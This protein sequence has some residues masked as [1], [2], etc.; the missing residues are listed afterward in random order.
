[1]KDDP[2]RRIRFGP[3][4]ADLAAGEL[5]K[6]GRVV[7]LQDQPFQILATL[8]D[9]PGEVITRDELRLRLWPG[10][11]YGDFDQ[12]LNTAVNKL[13]EALG[14][15]PSNPRFVETLPK[16]GYR[17]IHLVER[18]GKPSG[19]RRLSAWQPERKRAA[20]LTLAAILAIPAAVLS[21]RAG[22]RSEPQP[23]LPLRRFTVRRPDPTYTLLDARR[24]AISPN[25]R[26]VAIVADAGVGR[27]WIQDLDQEQPRL[28]EGSGGALTVFWSP[29]SG[30]VGFAVAGGKLR[31]VPARGGAPAPVA[32]TGCA[33]ISGA[34]WSPDGASILFACS[35][36]TGLYVTPSAGG[37]PER[38]VSPEMLEGELQERAE[39]PF[40]K[41]SCVFNPHFLPIKGGG[42]T[43][44]FVYKG[45][46]M[47]KNLRT[48]RQHAAG[49]GFEPVYASEGY[50]LYRLGTDLWARPFSPQQAKFAGEGAL[51]ARN[52][53]DA[54]VASDGTLVYRDAVFEQLAWVDRR[55]ARLET[56]GPVVKG[57]WYPAVSPDG[58][59]IAAETL[60]N[61][62]LDIWVS[63]ARGAR[64]RLTSHPATEILPVWSPSGDEVA[65]GSYQ[66]GNIDIFV[67]KADGGP[68][69]RP[70]VATP[71]NERVSDWSRDG[72]YITYSMAHPDN[73]HDLWYLERNAGGGWEPHPFLRTEF[74]EKSPKLSPDG[75]YVAYLSDESG[76][77]E[78][79]VRQFPSGSRKWAVS[80]GGASQMR[81]SRNGREIFY[82][83]AGALVAAE[84]RLSPGFEAG[85][86][87]RLFAHSAFNSSWTDANYD[88]SPDGRRVLVSER[89]GGQEPV[90]HVVQNWLAGFQS[91]R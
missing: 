49:P 80:S 50:L 61:D 65:F 13:R 14:D 67:R 54:S 85:P 29:D 27:L 41:S 55:G 4:E 77:D 82:V 83:E 58:S 36:P 5:R 70:L 69:G 16:R 51:V 30:T 72:R 26:H 11:S 44:L 21:L 43:V 74:N 63:D 66:A 76:R 73:G 39:E 78:V 34:A 64:I 3:F 1:M 71:H 15:S 59:R 32:E 42:Q 86:A 84:V 40:Q 57:A 33:H 31:K 18:L 6:D 35:S 28:I 2:E 48:G 20:A 87:T 37:T 46:L 75:R 45:Q 90:I 25:G 22:R 91:R 79:Y 81:W 17:F 89:V 56:A 53:T 8:L 68:E 10:D 24:V 19:E 62:S 52:A 88:V 60:E 23:Q 9:R 12:G 38:V 7:R 47:A